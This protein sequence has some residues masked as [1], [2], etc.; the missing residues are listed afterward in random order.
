[1]VTLSSK[2]APSGVLTNI[3]SEVL[4]DLSDVA[5]TSPSTDQVLA[6]NGTTW[7]PATAAPS[8][9]STGKAIAMAIV[10]G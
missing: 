6:W 10:F 5:N 3:N 1:M 7:A 2:I 4:S 9:I 8:G